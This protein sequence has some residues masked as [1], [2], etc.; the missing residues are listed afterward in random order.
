MARTYLEPNRNS[1]QKPVGGLLQLAEKH[2]KTTLL[3]P[4]IRAVDCVSAST[5]NAEPR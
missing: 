1:L 2:A 3:L 4:L 5:A